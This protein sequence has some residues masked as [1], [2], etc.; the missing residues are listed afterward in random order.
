M[1][2]RK[3]FH[4]IYTFFMVKTFVNSVSFV[5]KK[6]SQVCVVGG[7]PAGFVAAIAAARGGARTTLVESF[8]FPGGMATAGLV[9]PI[10]KFNFAGRRVVGGIA[11]EFVE[12]LAAAGGA[13]ADLPKGN[14]P[15]EAETYA[16]VAREMLEEAGVWC[17]WQ[18]QAC[19][20]PELSPDG[21]IAAVT[22][23]TAGFLS[24]LEADV[25]IDCTASGAIVGHRGFGAFRSPKGAAQPLSL[26]FILGGVDTACVRVVVRDDG[27]R[28]ANPV[29][30]AAL[31]KAVASGRIRSF[32]GPWALWGSTIRPGFVSVNATRAAADVTD[33]AEVAAAT[34][35]M[36]REIPEIA[37]VF[38][39][40][41]PAFRDCYVARTA[42]AT[43]F[44]ECRELK[45]LHRV[46]A[47][48]FLSGED[49]PDAVALAA[50]PM[51]RHVAGTSAQKLGFL[52][53]PG[54]I[55][56]SALIAEKCPNLLA[57]GGLA[58]A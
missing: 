18:T 25:F 23:S 1:Q 54:V 7:G 20:A 29:L 46:T 3:S 45:A 55:P 40:A 5:A 35:L 4:T 42:A 19:G 37:E 24:R 38:R 28:S 14:V 6:I 58:A 17:L 15:F 32:G 39:E 34:A 11:W 31:E 12:R 47:A 26:C 30:R 51:D 36:R 13:I 2:N 52:E 22:L 10:S 8:G 49:V 56:L 43:G 21:A 16:R 48:E 53:R 50:H 27:E 33:A 9:G 44:R 57:A 41:D